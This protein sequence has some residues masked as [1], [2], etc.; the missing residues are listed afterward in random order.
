MVYYGAED[1][2]MRILKATYKR[3]SGSF[4]PVEPVELPDGATV[5]VV[6]PES[7]TAET[8]GAIVVPDPTPD[9]I[10]TFHRSAGGWRDLV[11][12]EFVTE[13]YKRREIRRHPVD[14]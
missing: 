13:I 5:D 7:T 3:G 8:A 2:H 6:V 4:E 9:A 1:R 11:S 10:E 14:L 12:E